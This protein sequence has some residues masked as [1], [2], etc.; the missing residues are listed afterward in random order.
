MQA[1]NQVQQQIAFGFHSS[2]H[3]GD[4]TS[5]NDLQTGQSLSVGKTRNLPPVRETHTQ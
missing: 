1:N 2:S 3:R 5:S 4:I